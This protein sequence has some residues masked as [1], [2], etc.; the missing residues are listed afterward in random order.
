M[1]DHKAKHLVIGDEPKPGKSQPRSTSLFQMLEKRW[2]V[3]RRSQ[4]RPPR[5]IQKPA[6]PPPPPKS[7][8]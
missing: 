7:T 2:A 8:K 1:S 5:D 3:Q 4:P 6:P